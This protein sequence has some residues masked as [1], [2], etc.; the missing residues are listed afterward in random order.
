MRDDKN[1]CV[2]RDCGAP[3]SHR[4]HVIYASE[5]AIAPEGTLNPEA[6][7]IADELL[8]YCEVCYGLVALVS[9]VVINV[10]TDSN[11]MWR[12]A[13]YAQLGIPG[14]NATQLK[15]R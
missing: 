7:I 10:D 14:E 4:V 5:N 2:Y 11:Y 12:Q 3:A 1:E 15:S 6:A 8:P 9:P 13:T